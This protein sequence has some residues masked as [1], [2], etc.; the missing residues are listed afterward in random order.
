MEA[1]ILAGGKGTRIRPLTYTRPKPLLPML[2]RTLV[3]R[4]LDKMPK[5]VDRVLMPVN[6]LSELMVAH[7]EEHP[8]PRLEFI[9][10][11]EPLG[12][13]GALKNCQKHFTGPFL[14]YNGDIVAS[15]DLAQMVRFHERKKAKATVSLFPVAEPWHFGVVR[16]NGN[17]RIEEFVEKPPR[18]KEPSNLCNAGQYILDPSVLDEIPK[19]TFY[20]L[21]KESFEP[22]AKRGAGLFGFQFEGYWVDCGR[23]ESYLEA[24]RVLLKAEGK[25]S[26]AGKGVKGLRDAQFSGYALGDGV[27]LGKGARVERSVLLPNAIVGAKAVVRDSVLGEGVEVE[28]GAVLERVAVG[29]FAVVQAGSKIRD[30]RIGMRPGDE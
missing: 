20:S 26:V 10:E 27:E 4:V 6:Y 14:V 3:E 19:D 5:E 22:M 23:P 17:G 24:H 11:P 30:Q 29:D 9:D 2:N 12:T 28:E 25:E 21:E 18:G 15:V 1:L 8:D 7:F 16:L 13:G